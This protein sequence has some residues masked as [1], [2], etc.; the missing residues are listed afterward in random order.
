MSDKKIK[1]PEFIEI[2]MNGQT[3]F[4]IASTP[5]QAK[6]YAIK[7]QVKT[8]RAGV[9]ARKVGAAEAIR[10]GLN[11]DNVVDLR[12]SGVAEVEEAPAA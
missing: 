9:T 2:T 4:V 6:N 10:L 5:A 3:G 8:L 1:D 12:A 11:F 7:E